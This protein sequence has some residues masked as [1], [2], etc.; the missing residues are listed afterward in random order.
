MSSDCNIRIYCECSLS[1]P[2][3]STCDMKRGHVRQ[4]WF[5]L[6]LR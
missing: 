4:A 2:E 3:S 6:V 1:S 5:G